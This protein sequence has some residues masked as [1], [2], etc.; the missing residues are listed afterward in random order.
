M[1]LHKIVD[2]APRIQVPLRVSLNLIRGYPMFT[3]VR[4]AGLLLNAFTVR[5]SLVD[6]TQH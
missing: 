2:S 6:N 3:I 5:G 4:L 1:G